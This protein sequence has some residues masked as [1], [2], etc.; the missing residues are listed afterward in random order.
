MF[1]D[2]L[3]LAGGREVYH[4]PAD[5]MLPYFESLGHS[6]PEHYN[7]AEVRSCFVFLALLGFFGTS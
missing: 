4:G 5:G 3:L 2:L 6:C 7:P 1:D